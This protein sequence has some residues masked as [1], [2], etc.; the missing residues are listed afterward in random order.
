M[1]P[2]AIEGSITHDPVKCVTR[3]AREI[4]LVFVDGCK[5][6]DDISGGPALPE[7]GIQQSRRMPEHWTE[8]RQGE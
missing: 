2:M 5:A 8:R 7:S 1:R 4:V 3:I 6:G